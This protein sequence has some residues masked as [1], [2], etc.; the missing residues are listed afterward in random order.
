MWPRIAL[1]SSGQYATIGNE[2][3]WSRMSEAMTVLTDGDGYPKTKIHGLRMLD[4]VVFSHIP[5]SSADSTNV[6]RNI[7]ID[8][9]WNGAYAPSTR[10]QR[11]LI[12][13][14]RIETHAPASRWNK[15]SSGVQHNFQLLG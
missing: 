14:E 3:W 15:E 7:G 12:L 9:R 5:F 8:A 1:G 13:M 2:G 10:Y 11:A 4:P 6:A